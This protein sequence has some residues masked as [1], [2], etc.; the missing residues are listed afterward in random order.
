MCLLRLSLLLRGVAV[1]GCDLFL[2]NDD[3]LLG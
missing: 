3:R 1:Q 2:A